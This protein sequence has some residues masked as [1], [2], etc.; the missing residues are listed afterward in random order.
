PSYNYYDTYQNMPT[1]QS[2]YPPQNGAA[3]GNTVVLNITVPPDAEGWINDTKTAVTGAFRQFESPPLTPGKNFVYQI[4]VKMGGN[5]LTRDV[6]VHA[7][8]VV[9]LDFTNSGPGGY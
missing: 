9:N 6:T 3:T 8:D 4:R 5:E 7:G 2:L 1:Y